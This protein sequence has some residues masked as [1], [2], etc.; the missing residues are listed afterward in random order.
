MYPSYTKKLEQLAND[1]MHGKK[2]C[3]I[4]GA[5]LSVASGVTPYRCGKHAIWSDFVLEVFLKKN[6]YKFVN[7]LVGNEKKIYS[8]SIKMV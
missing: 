1:L 3:F 8:R 7:N 4:T 5:G 2:A 6:V